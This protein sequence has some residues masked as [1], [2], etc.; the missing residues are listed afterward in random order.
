MK[1]EEAMRKPLYPLKKILLRSMMK[2]VAAM[3]KTLH[4]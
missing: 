4:L 1:K 3:R 2:K